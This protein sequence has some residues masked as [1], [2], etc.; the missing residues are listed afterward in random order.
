MSAR[1]FVTGANGFIGSHLVH[2]LCQQGYAVRALV[3]TQSQRDNLEGL[4]VETITGDLNDPE[5]ARAMRGC[6][7]LFHLAAC[8]SLWWADRHRLHASNVR[9]TQNVLAAARQAGIERTVFTGSAVNLD[10]SRRA[11]LPNEAHSASPQSLASP[12]ERSKY[13]AEQAALSAASSGQ[14]V[15]VAIPT[16]PLGPGDAKPTPAGDIVLR[17][18]RRQMPVYMPTGFNAI[19]VRDAAWGHLLA[20]ERGRSG[21]RYLLGCQNLA[22]KALLDRLAELTGLTAPK[23]A[24]PPWLPAIAAWAD[25]R[26]LALAGK[27]P[28]VPLEGVRMAA[29]PLYCDCSKAVRELGLPQSPL[30]GALRDAVRWFLERGYAKLE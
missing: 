17:F 5:L 15:V 14:S 1:A 21:E 4:A 12:Y 6:Q 26:V 2:L 18:L 16:T 3:R 30:E 28:S 25:E 9:G 13:W 29:R 8:N 10:T 22:L 24:V 19:D 27:S 23:V 11:S 7:Y 20:L